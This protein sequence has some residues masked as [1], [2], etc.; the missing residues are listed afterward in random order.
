MRAAAALVK[1]GGLVLYVTCALAEAEN[2]GL[3]LSLKQKHSR[4]SFVSSLGPGV[5]SKFLKKFGQNFALDAFP[6][7]A[8]RLLQGADAT[9][10]GVQALGL[11]AYHQAAQLGLSQC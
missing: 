2:D 4:R 3:G 8:S 1:P 11:R 10:C 9:Q 7:Q 5:V 6:D